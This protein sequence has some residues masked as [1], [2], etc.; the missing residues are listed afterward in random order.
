MADYFSTVTLPNTYDLLAPDGAEVRILA[1]LAAGSMAHFRLQANQVSRAVRHQTVEEIWYVLEGRGEMWRSWQGQE[2]ITALS[3][4]T[5]L[6]IPAGILFQ[7]RAGA[8][9]SISVVSVTIPPWPGED[10]AVI[11]D[12]K[13]PPAI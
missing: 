6:T 13:W 7:F 8:D 9:T 2:D 5:S 4:G 11:V 1:I 12:G 3:P 10:E